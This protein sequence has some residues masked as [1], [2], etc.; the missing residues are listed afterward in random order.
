MVGAAGFEPT[1]TTP[2]TRHTVRGASPDE[3]AT[4]ESRLGKRRLTAV[5]R[6]LSPPQIIERSF[7]MAL[8]SRSG[9]TPERGDNRPDNQAGLEALDCGSAQTARA[10]RVKPDPVAV[11]KV[12][13]VDV[14]SPRFAHETPA[15]RCPVPA[16]L[17]PE[18]GTPLV[19]RYRSLVIE[20]EQVQGRISATQRRKLA[21]GRAPRCPLGRV[22]AT[23]FVIR[24]QAAVAEGG[25]WL[26][27]RDHPAIFIGLGRGASLIAA[28]A[29]QFF[30]R[31]DVR[32]LQ[33]AHP[34]PE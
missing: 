5:V 33:R 28:D 27:P 10:I 34:V 6:T 13:W 19:H 20:H 16:N 23:E 2:Q 1:T 7:E 18:N 4:H 12:V 3:R 11:T 25:V 22:S 14:G 15:P 32:R 31:R 9:D 24:K 21:K 8:G 30:R 17:G 26:L 29:V